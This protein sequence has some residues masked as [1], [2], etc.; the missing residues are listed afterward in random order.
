MPLSAMLSWRTMG[1][2]TSCAP[3]LLP[4]QDTSCKQD[5]NNALELFCCS[6][7][8]PRAASL[9]SPEL[10]FQ[11]GFGQM[12]PP[13]SCRRCTHTEQSGAVT[14]SPARAGELS[15]LCCEVQ[16]ITAK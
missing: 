4:Q 14:T 3:E 9:N 8:R 2:L 7:L 11:R 13:G 16:L 10:D 12:S 1:P 6:E 5:G 15:G